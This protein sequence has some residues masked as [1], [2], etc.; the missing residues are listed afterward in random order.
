MAL[1]PCLDSFM[2][3]NQSITKAHRE[4]RSFIV[5]PNGGRIGMAILDIMMTFN[6]SELA[7]DD[8]TS[9]RGISREDLL[10]AFVSELGE[11]LKVTK[12]ELTVCRFWTQKDT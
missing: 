5:G 7:I 9:N 1:I 3:S 2:E 6:T 8:I 12:P 10:N 11:E 4:E